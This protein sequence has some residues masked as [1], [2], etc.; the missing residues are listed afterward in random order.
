MKNQKIKSFF[1]TRIAKSLA[2]F[3]A[4]AIIGAAVY[5]N[6][7]LFYDPVDS[8]GF[9]DNNMD[10]AFGGSA[11]TGGSA[12]EDYFTAT[13]LNR[14]QS[15]D[16][17]IDVLKLVVEN[18]EASAEVKAAARKSVSALKRWALKLKLP[19]TKMQLHSTKLISNTMRFSVQLT[20][21]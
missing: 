7:R 12:E 11:D 20:M 18:V 4:V 15:R 14:Q 19:I 8:M 16:E 17:A 3:L 5:V 21:L 2:V 13:A 9:G 6:Y 10:D 1:S